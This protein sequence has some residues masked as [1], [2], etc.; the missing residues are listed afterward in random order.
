M[1]L[2]KGLVALDPYSFS[3]AAYLNCKASTNSALLFE[4]QYFSRSLNKMGTAW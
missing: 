1:V 4:T 3:K 2:G